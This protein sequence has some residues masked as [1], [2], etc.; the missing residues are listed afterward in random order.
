MSAGAEAV[1]PSY[2]EIRAAIAEGSMTF[3][4]FPSLDLETCVTEIVRRQAQRPLGLVA[5]REE[6]AGLSGR[7]QAVIVWLGECDGR[8][9]TSRRGRARRSDR[10]AAV[11]IITFRTAVQRLVPIEAHRV[12]PAPLCPRTEVGRVPKHV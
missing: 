10:R 8:V 1:H 6:Q 2:V 7:F 5:W 4:L 12:G 9:L 3:V 11:L